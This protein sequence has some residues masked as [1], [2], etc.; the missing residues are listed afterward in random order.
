MGQPP[1]KQARERPSFSLFN[2][3]QV[4]Y[5]E[6]FYRRPINL[7]QGMTQPRFYFG[8]GMLLTLFK[9]LNPLINTYS[10]VMY[11]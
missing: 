11:G 7:L 4:L 3:L 6:N 9:P 5:T 1:V 10:G 2:L 8:V